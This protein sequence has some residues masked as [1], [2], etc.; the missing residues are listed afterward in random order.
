MQIL[1]VQVILVWLLRLS[2]CSAYRF[3]GVFPLAGRSHYII[4]ES[5]MKGLIDKGHQVDVMSP[6]LQKKPYPNYTDIAEFKTHIVL[7]NNLS[8]DYIMDEVYKNPLNVIATSFGN[9]ICERYLGHP[10]IQK[11]VRNPPKDPPY[12]AMIMEV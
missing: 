11:L 6:F 4:A 8:Y 2:A 7:L 9:E 10:A 1:Q 5:L 12:D 3:L